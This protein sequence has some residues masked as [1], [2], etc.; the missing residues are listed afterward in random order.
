MSNSFCLWIHLRFVLGQFY[1]NSRDVCGLPCKHVSVVLQELNG[2]IFVF[3]DEARADGCR[4]VCVREAKVVLLGSSNSC[5][6]VVGV[7]S[8]TGIM[9]SSPGGVSVF[10]I[11]CRGATE[12]PAVRAIWMAPGSTLLLLGS[13]PS[14]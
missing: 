8:F 9:R 12:G 6:E 2:R 5:M 13:R 3:G 4:L 10:V 1:G 14:W 11:G 7:A